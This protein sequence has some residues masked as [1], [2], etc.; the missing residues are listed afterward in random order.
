MLTISSFKRLRAKVSAM[1]T[2]QAAVSIHTYA[3][4]A[5]AL[6]TKLVI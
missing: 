5:D 1:D 2:V 4:Y 3:E 6:K